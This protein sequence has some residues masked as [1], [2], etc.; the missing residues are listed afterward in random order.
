MQKLARI[1]HGGK[2]HTI[3]LFDDLLVEELNVLLKTLFNIEGKIL[4]FLDQVSAQY[5]CMDP[6]NCKLYFTSASILTKI[7]RPP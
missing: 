5:V 3:A 2:T 6:I 4:G 7:S 1:T